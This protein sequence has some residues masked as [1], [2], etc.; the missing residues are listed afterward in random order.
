LLVDLTM[1]WIDFNVSLFSINITINVQNLSFLVD[2][3]WCLPFKEL[4]P[5]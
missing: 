1:L 4:P 2:K 5:S 3:E